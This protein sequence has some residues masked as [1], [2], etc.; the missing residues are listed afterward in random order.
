MKMLLGIKGN[1]QVSL[2]KMGHPKSS[3]VW[4]FEEGKGVKTFRN[5]YKPQWAS[6]QHIIKAVSQPCALRDTRMVTTGGDEEED[7]NFG[8]FC[9]G[10][11][12]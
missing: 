10:W 1:Q 12:E 4:N 9:K 3:G 8:F 11:C 6:A 7:D 5:M 2:W